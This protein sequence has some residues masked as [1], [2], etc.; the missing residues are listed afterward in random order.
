[1]QMFT[2]I[3]TYTAHPANA[4]EVCQLLQLLAQKSRAE[5]ANLS[6][7]V[8]QDLEA[9]E[10]FYILETYESEAGFKDHRASQHFE[11]IGFGRIFP[12]LV[13]REVRGFVPSSTS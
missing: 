11:E 3:A 7:S 4:A 10:R 6:Y 2:V 9:P 12:L 13:N 8:S 5:T 1:M